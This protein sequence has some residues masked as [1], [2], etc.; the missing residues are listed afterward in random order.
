MNLQAFIGRE[1]WIPLEIFDDLSFEDFKPL[2]WMEKARRVEGIDSFEVVPGRGLNKKDNFR[3]KQIYIFRYD[4]Q[5]GK[6]SGIWASDRSE[7]EISRLEICFDVRENNMD[8]M[9]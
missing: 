7:I 3:W 9:I 1:Q 5:T 8:M 4:K 2:E 6:F